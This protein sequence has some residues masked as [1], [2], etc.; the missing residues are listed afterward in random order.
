MTAPDTMDDAIRALAKN[1][2]QFTVEYCVERARTTTGGTPALFE[3]REEIAEEI[4]ETVMECA[5]ESPD[6]EVHAVRSFA[7]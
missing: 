3:I 7:G 5:D 6:S 1:V 4:A 2:A